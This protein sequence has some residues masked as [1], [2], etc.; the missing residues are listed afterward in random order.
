MRSNRRIVRVDMSSPENSRVILDDG[1]ELVGIKSIKAH[2]SFNDITTVGI[3]A[4]VYPQKGT[5]YEHYR[6]G[7]RVYLSTSEEARFFENR[8]PF[9][10]RRV[11]V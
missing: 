1:S 6:N 10:W 8:N 11:R 5:T 4:Y 3:E 2:T 9:H 7:E